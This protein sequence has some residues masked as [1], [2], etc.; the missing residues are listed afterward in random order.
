LSTLR[1]ALRLELATRH[2][3]ASPFWHVSPAESVCD[4]GQVNSEMESQSAGF[5]ALH[6]E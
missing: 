5:P 2:P 3:I 4:F 1:F 6:D